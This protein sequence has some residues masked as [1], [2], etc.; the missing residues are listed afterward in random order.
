MDVTFDMVQWQS[1]SDDYETEIVDRNISQYVHQTKCNQL[2][3]Y[4][5]ES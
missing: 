4:Y 2:W 5:Y 1:K 3:T